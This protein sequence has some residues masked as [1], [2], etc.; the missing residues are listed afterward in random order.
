M[1]N[2]RH[3]CMFNSVESF[4]RYYTF[5]HKPSKMAG[6]CNIHLFRD[7]NLPMWE[8]FPDGGCWILKLS[9]NGN[10]VDRVWEKLV[11]S[12]IGEAFQEP[13][14]VGVVLSVRARQDMVAIWNKDYK[15][16]SARFG[17]GEKLKQLLQLPPSTVLEYKK[18]MSSIKDN[19]TYRNAKTY[20]VAE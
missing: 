3:L 4:W 11:L 16:E 7:G 2:L 8:S 20:V 9:K 19:S 14:L 10:L 5:L 18:H 15:S 13:D 1:E 6:E 17:I 12:V